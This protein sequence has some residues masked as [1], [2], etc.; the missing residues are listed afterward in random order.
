[1]TETNYFFVSSRKVGE[2]PQGPWG[3][4]LVPG[5]LYLIPILIPILIPLNII[6][7]HFSKFF[8]FEKVN[9]EVKNSK[10]KVRLH[11]VKRARP[12][13][14]LA[15][16]S[17]SSIQDQHPTNS[18][19]KTIFNKT[20]TITTRNNAQHQPQHPPQRQQQQQQQPQQ[21]Q[22]FTIAIAVAIEIAITI[23]IAIALTI[24]TTKTIVIQEH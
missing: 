8:L 1:M 13:H 12:P 2:N 4:P 22:Q 14:V 3:V 17:G 21:H 16:M 7:L 5:T 10:G 15:Y 19:N 18:V 6:F 24:T 9:A 11:G 20:L 23:A